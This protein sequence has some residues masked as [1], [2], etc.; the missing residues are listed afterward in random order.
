MA[1]DDGLD[2]FAAYYAQGDELVK[3]A[4]KEELAE[5]GRVLAM[6]VAFYHARHGPVPDE[7]VLRAMAAGSLSKPDIDQLTMSAA[8]FAKT[9]GMVLAGDELGPEIH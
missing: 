1:E 4:T 8:M 3:R 7:D 6:H 9:L 2:Q 5:A